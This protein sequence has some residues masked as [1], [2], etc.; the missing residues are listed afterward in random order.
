MHGR[1]V[2]TLHVIERDW[3]VDE[4]AEQS[5]SDKFQNATATKK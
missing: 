3:R 5:G 4:E 1:E 2:Q